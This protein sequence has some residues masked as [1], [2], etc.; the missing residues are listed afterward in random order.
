LI[1]GAT[2]VSGKLAIQVAR[3]LGA[4]RIIGTGRN[5]A[6][7]KSLSG[8]GADAVIDLE[9]P[10]PALLASFQKEAGDA[11]YDIIVDYLW[12]HPSEVLLKSLIPRELG[13]AKKPVRFIHIGE[14]AG[15]SIKLSG[16]MLRTSGLELY[17][18][19]IM[20]PEA[21]QQG[22]A[23]VW[24][25]IR[26][27]ALSIDIETVRLSDIEKAWQREDLAGKRLVVLP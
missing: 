2:G 23:Q 1:N 3:M 9:Q 13:F 24:D 25:W 21:L 26:E 12:G 17:G 4:G 18:V 5:Q 22:V 15:S 19:G 16:E 8:V 10:D 20:S 7:L 14:K 11:G 6:T 27:D